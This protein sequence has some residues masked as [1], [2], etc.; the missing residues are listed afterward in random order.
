MTI[1]KPWAVP[2]AQRRPGRPMVGRHIQCADA[3]TAT[4][5][6]VLARGE[7]I[8]R[9]KCSACH[10]VVAGD[11]RIPPLMRSGNRASEDCQ[12]PATTQASVQN[13]ITTTHW[14]HK[15]IP[16]TMPD[17]KLTPEEAVEDS[18]RRQHIMSLR[19]Q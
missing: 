8:A 3:D 9:Q 19:K 4:A 11:Q 18:L 15:T 10:V 12:Q 13:L 6:P 16:M 1:S 2:G 5:D 7:H 14:D 17:P